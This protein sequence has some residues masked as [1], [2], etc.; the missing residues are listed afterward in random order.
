MYDRSVRLVSTSINF[1]E[2]IFDENALINA[3][4]NIYARY[5]GHGQV[6]WIRA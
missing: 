1:A 3:P 6:Q 5:I 4:T 2:T